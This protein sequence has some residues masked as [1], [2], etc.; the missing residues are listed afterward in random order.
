[1]KIYRISGYG[2]TY[3]IQALDRQHAKIKFI[4]NINNSEKP[5]ILLTEA[6]TNIISEETMQQCFH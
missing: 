6:N 1:M 3:N 4:N 5:T 2:Y